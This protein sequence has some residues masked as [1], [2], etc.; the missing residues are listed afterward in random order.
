MHEFKVKFYLRAKD[1]LR[2][3]YRSVLVRIYLD[4]QRDNLAVSHIAV[5]ADA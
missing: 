3:G 4:H 1:N 5:P 2:T